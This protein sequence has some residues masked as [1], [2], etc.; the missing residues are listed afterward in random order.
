MNDT[1]AIRIAARREGF[2]RAGMAHPLGPVEHPPGTFTAEQIEQILADPNLVADVLDGSASQQSAVAPELAELVAAIPP[3]QLQAFAEHP[4]RAR[5]LEPPHEDIF[6]GALA[7]ATP[8]L[9]DADRGKD[10]KPKVPALEKLT[11]LDWDAKSR[12]A[13]WARL[14]EL[15]AALTPEEAA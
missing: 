7:V 11:G 8:Q 13:A 1:P 10:G 15:V 4:D 5:L 9:T 3:E 14:P 6:L 2:R 12:D